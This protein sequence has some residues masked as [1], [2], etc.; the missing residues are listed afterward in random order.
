MV[1]KELSHRGSSI[2]MVKMNKV[3]ILSERVHHHQYIV[4]MTGFGKA[5]HKVQRNDLPS[6]IRIRERL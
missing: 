1:K 3:S 4:S 2:W 5:F 6:R